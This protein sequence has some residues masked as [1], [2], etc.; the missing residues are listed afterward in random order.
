MI[1]PSFESYLLISA[2]RTL[3]DGND[4]SWLSVHEIGYGDDRREEVGDVT[5]VVTEIR[6]Y[7]SDLTTDEFL[8]L[9][10]DFVSAEMYSRE[11]VEENDHNYVCFD[12]TAYFIGA[13]VESRY[14]EMG[15]ADNVIRRGPCDPSFAQDIE[16][17]A[18][19]MELAK[20]KIPMMADR[21]NELAESI[22]TAEP[23]VPDT[24][25]TS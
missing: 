13:H 12:G 15:N 14:P 19:L 16:I 7:I 4:D 1:L 10:E 17:A 3:N 20:S 6:K 22:R 5:T 11:V 24:E 18:S 8:E 2:R 23:I 21:I 9:H 25:E